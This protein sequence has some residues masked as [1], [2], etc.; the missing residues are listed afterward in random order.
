VT[1]AD[2]QRTGDLLGPYRPLPVGRT[3][4]E[5]E[6]LLAFRPTLG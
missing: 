3:A 5:L 6:V 1:G 4:P 2:E